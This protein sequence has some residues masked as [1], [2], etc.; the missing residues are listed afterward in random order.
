M[1][2]VF[3]SFLLNGNAIVKQFGLGLAA[4]IAIDAT[5]VRCLAVPAVMA[6][7][8]KA[9]WWLPRWLDRALPKISIEGEDY[10]EKRDAEQPARV[11]PPPPPVRV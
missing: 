9:A 10:F 3:S 1:V 7:L 4:A 6:L 2:F 8:G 5:I 11:P